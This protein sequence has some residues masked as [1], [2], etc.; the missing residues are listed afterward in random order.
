MSQLFS[1]KNFNL[2]SFIFEKETGQIFSSALILFI[3]PLL[4]LNQ[5]VLGTVVNALLIK[6]AITCKTKK[7]FILSLVP[8]LAA[9]TGGILFGGLTAQLLLV[10]PF[11]W[12]GNFAIMLLMRKLYAISKK[13]FFYSALASAT[14]KTALLFTSVLILFTQALVPLLFL[15]VFG[16]NQFITAACGAVLVFTAS[17]VSKKI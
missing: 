9:V 16:L 5:L 6:N 2:Y 11:I 3:L 8:S 4:P 14:A 1:K 13:E 7:V 17:W 12:A 15:T 10:I